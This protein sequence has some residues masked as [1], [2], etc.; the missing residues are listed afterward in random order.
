MHKEYSFPSDVWSAGVI[1]GEILK[2]IPE[3]CSK[4]ASRTPLLPGKICFPLSPKTRRNGDD[5]FPIT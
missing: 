4:V 5:G 1:F 2:M 3:N